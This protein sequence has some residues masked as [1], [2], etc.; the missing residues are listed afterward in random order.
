LEEELARLGYLEGAPP[1]V[2]PALVDVDRRIG[3]RMKCGACHKRGMRFHPMHKAS[4]YR[5]VLVCRCGN[6]EEM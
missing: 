4:A 3:R 6:R 2:P 5:V 1:Q